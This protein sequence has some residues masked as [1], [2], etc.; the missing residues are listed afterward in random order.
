MNPPVMELMDLQRWIYELFLKNPIDSQWNNG[1]SFIP[2]FHFGNSIWYP[3]FSISQAKCFSLVS[4]IIQQSIYKTNKGGYK[5][6]TI[7]P[8]GNHV[9][10]LIQVN[11]EW[12]S[13]SKCCFTLP[14][15]KNHLK[16]LK[17]IIISNEL[18]L[19]KCNL[20]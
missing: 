3:L 10:D 8:F 5:A 6:I 4:I 11:N 17:S 19:G 1:I 2:V 16:H 20:V 18:K 14:Q 13:A 12:Y 9:I 7:H 15:L